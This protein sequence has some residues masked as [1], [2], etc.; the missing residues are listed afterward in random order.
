MPINFPF[1]ADYIFIHLGKEN[2]ECS[3]TSICA[4]G[5]FCNFDLYE[6]GFC[7]TCPSADADNACEAEDFLHEVGTD[8]CK[9][10]CAQPK[11]PRGMKVWNRKL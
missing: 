7:E 3:N 9:K 4:I 2:V 10:R 5:E 1:I 8:D 11:K 6:S